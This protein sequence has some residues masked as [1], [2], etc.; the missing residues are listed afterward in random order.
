MPGTVQTPAG[1]GLGQTPT[2]EQTRSKLWQKSVDLEATFITQ[3]M[4]PMFDG[5][6]ATEPF[7][8]G[9]AED[10]WRS[11]ELDE[12][13]KAIARSGGI[14]LAPAIYRQLLAVQEGKGN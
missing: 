8:G 4:K 6:Q 9:N 13:G 2:G 7:G 14:G 12:F 5:T 10:V 3:M 11:F 1:A